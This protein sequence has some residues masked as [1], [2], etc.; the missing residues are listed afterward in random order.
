MTLTDF[1]LHI[2]L[3]FTKFL[4]YKFIPLSY[5]EIIVNPL[6][7]FAPLFMS[8]VMTLDNNDYLSRCSKL[9]AYMN[10]IK[11]V[12]HFKCLYALFWPVCP[13]LIGRVARYTPS[14]ELNIQTKIEHR[15][16]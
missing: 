9:I 2:S 4:Y 10:L 15:I 14:S 12:M 3:T 8:F 7:L 11:K 6:L 16:I 5:P 1:T 13:A